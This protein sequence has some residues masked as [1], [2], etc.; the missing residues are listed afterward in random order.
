VDVDTIRATA[1][2]SRRT[3]GLFESFAA[4]HRLPGPHNIDI[5]GNW[6]GTRIWKGLADTTVFITLFLTVSGL[7]LWFALKAERVIGLLLI[8]AG[9][10]SLCGVMYAIVR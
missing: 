9:A 4:W 6:L 3:T 1:V 2:V 7:Y 10:L 8:T 5:R